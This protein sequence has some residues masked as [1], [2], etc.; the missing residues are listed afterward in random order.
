MN[1]AEKHGGNCWGWRYSKRSHTDVTEGSNQP[2]HHKQPSSRP[3][4]SLCS[5]TRTVHLEAMVLNITQDQNQAPVGSFSIY[6]SA[7]ALNQ[8]SHLLTKLTWLYWA[9]FCHLSNVIE[10]IMSHVY[11]F[12]Q[13]IIFFTWVIQRQSNP[14]VP[15]SLTFKL[16]H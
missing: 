8:T 13:N 6:H 14:Y 5:G 3:T 4:G 11:Y 2:P 1:Q 10:L 16:I 9:P 7:L 12:L 15:K